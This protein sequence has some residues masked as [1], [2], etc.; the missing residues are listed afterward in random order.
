MRPERLSWGEI[1]ELLHAANCG[2]ANASRQLFAL[3]YG[4]LKRLAHAKLYKGCPHGELNTTSLVHESFVKLARCGAV[5]PGDRPAFFAYVGEVMRS[6]VL[7]LFREG[8][9]HKRGS[10]ARGSSR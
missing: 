7:D 10:E 5:A 6:V 9:A 2:D 4:D 1:T 3:L 8:P